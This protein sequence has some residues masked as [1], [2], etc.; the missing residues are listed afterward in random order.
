MMLFFLSTYNAR[1][2][3]TS[4]DNAKQE[5][6]ITF[7]H[8]GSVMPHRTFDIFLTFRRSSRVVGF[9]LLHGH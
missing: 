3:E 1:M 9:G 5:N 2:L 7:L 4:A 8:Y 6:Y